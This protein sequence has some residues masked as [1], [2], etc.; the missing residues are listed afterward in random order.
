MDHFVATMEAQQ[1]LDLTG[2]VSEQTLGVAT[3]IRHQ[4]ARDLLPDRITHDERVATLERT[5]DAH[6]ARGQQTFAP[7][8]GSGRTLIYIKLASRL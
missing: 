6:H 8:E 7:T 2:F 3:R 1:S 4:P 5:D